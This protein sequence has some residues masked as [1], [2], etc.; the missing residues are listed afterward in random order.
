MSDPQSFEYRLDNAAKIFAAQHSKRRTTMFRLSA[1]LAEPVKLSVLIEAY[2]Q[3]LKRC[4]YYQVEL[5]RGL[6]WYYLEPNPVT[7]RIE[8]ESRYPCLYIPVKKRGVVPFRLI[9]YGHTIAFEVAHFITD[10]T[11]ALEFLK[12]IIVAYHRLLGLSIPE[13]SVMID[14]AKPYA[15]G[16]FEDSFL[17][18]YKKQVPPAPM[19]SRSYK[20]RSRGV[21]PPA[22]Y[23]I[24]G[25]VETQR[26]KEKA[27]SYGVTVGEF[28]ASLMIDSALHLMHRHNDTKRPVRIS[29]P[30]N[31]RRFFPSVSMRNF[32]L[33]VE[34]GI[35]PR[36]GDYT[37]DDIVK[38]VHHFMKL[39]LD[40][41]YIRRQ[42]ARNVK[43]EKHPLI[44]I[45]P[46]F[47]KDPILKQF[48]R[49]FGSRV[50]TMSFS[51]LGLVRLP[52]SLTGEVKYFTFIPPPH[53]KTVSASAISYGQTTSLVFASTL[54]S[55]ELEQQFFSSLRKYG[56]TASIRTNRR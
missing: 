15:D 13:G 17:S 52:E 53:P 8:A 26:I 43:S 29:I 6:F 45:I 19:N 35:D 27:R 2:D 41:L 31:L 37:F 5:K 7:P 48:Y 23:V 18:A 4:P 3:M 44:R 47:L 49:F 32:A 9:A 25:R 38:A 42:I 36:L 33:T 28:V 20:I 55:T 12:G 54:L 34:P 46:L 56:V 30:I 16:E 24:E 1:E 22:F 10:G 40:T 51:N 11:G 50:F 39:E 21:K 14:P